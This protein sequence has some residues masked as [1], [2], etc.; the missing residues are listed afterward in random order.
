MT[1]QQREINQ[2]KHDLHQ[3]AKKVEK[4]MLKGLAIGI[5]STVTIKPI[6]GQPKT[7]VRVKD[8]R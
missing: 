2:Y 7:A 3:A 4:L 8:N 1:E 5:E 6:M